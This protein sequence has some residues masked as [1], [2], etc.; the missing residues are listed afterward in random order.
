[1]SCKTENNKAHED[2]KNVVTSSNTYLPA[3]TVH[4]LNIPFI[5]SKIVFFQLAVASDLYK[6]SLEARITFCM[7]IYAQYLNM[8]FCKIQ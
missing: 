8:D 1:M 3:C 7:R 2:F 5:S 6:I 4:Q